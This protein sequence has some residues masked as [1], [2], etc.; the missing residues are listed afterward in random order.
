[1]KAHIDALVALYA[2]HEV[3]ESRDQPRLIERALRKSLRDLSRDSAFP[4]D[5]NFVE[6]LK[7]RIENERAT[8]LTPDTRGQI[9][10]CLRMLLDVAMFDGDAP[11]RRELKLNTMRDLF[12]AMFSKGWSKAQIKHFD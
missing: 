7:R 2:G 3:K 8:L 4:E 1:M 11:S 12:M 9:G 10:A 6:S 5:K